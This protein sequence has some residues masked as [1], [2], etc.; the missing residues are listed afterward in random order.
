[1]LSTKLVLKAAGE[2]RFDPKGSDKALKN[3]D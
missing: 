3:L 1:M 2:L